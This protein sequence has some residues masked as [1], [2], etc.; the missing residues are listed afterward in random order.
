MRV[1]AS[2]VAR[3]IAIVALATLGV[4]LLG[5]AQRGFR[6]PPTYEAN[7]PYDGRF[8]FARIRYTPPPFNGYRMDVKWDHDY[9]RSDHHFPTIV[10]EITTIKSRT[11]VSNIL[12]LDDPE[13]M[14]FPWAYLCE[15][16][17]WHPTD[18]EVAGMRNYLLK[19]GFI[20]FDDF[21]RYDWDNFLEQMKRVFPELHPLPLT[22]DDRIFDSFY[23][24]ASLD[25]THPY[26]G[27]KAEFWGLYENNDRNG[28]L[29][30]VINYNNDVSEYWEWSD[31]G[32][33]PVAA[34]N[35]AYKL[36]VN[37]LVYAL[38]R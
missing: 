33:F 4:P 15:A 31:E 28:R 23:H 24:I 8:T 21:A 22:P 38:T 1:T 37:Y 6:G 10:G 20:V 3:V 25:Y 32:M 26:Y 16:G 29:M 11:L 18:A 35:E 27:V 34:S 12:T 14:K 19:G 30:A 13:L 5:W 9:P 36:G 7:A 2:T 17:Y